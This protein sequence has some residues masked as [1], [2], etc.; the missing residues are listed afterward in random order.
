MALLVADPERTARQL[1]DDLRDD[2]VA[3]EGAAVGLRPVLLDA[4]VHDRLAEDAVRFVRL[5]Q[6]AAWSRA[7]DATRL[8]AALG[9]GPQE[10]RP[11]GDQALEAASAGLFARP[12]AL[13][14]GGRARFLECN[15]GGALGGVMKSH[16]LLR[17]Y[18][19]LYPGLLGPAGTA[20]AVDPLAA[21]AEVY[22]DVCARLG[23]PSKVGILGTAREENIAGA[24][25]FGI[26]VDHLRSIGF[27]AAFVE[28]EDLDGGREAEHPVLSCHFIPSE[29]RRM[30]VPLEPVERAARAGVALLPSP[31]SAL[32]SDKT[33]LAWLSDGSVP[34]EPA[35]RAFLDEV[36]PW[37]RRVVAG[38]TEHEGSTV[39]LFT[40][41]VRRRE[42][43]V[44]KPARGFAGQ[45][46]LIGALSTPEQWRRE[47]DRAAAEGGWI[48]QRATDADPVPMDFLD[49]ATGSM[50]S[51]DSN[52]VVSPFVM[53]GRPAGC[54]VRHAPGRT[55]GVVNR[56]AGAATNVAVSVP[57]SSR[58]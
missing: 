2:P 43:L 7:A 8:A 51:T 29:W 13:L 55:A 40:L 21:K 35:D 28:P 41:A 37:T 34:L 19:K 3:L 32:L 47:L 23:L 5:V 39:D 25:Y 36:L 49:P 57:D 15:F 16:L 30:G 48:L 52:A 24:R 33:L 12:D 17:S 46:V 42:T 56:S 11:F 26:E 27:D 1:T 45:G 18:A 54:M 38:T 58:D 22:R 10:Y 9:L 31:A 50:V 53:G 20:R 4:A 6:H 44:L 14:S